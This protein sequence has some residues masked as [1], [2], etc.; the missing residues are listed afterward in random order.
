MFDARSKALEFLDR[1]FTPLFVSL[2][3]KRPRHQ[4]W[5]NIVQTR[6]N[7][8]RQFTRPAN[9]G[10]RTGD[11]HE[12]GSCLVAVDIDREDHELLA[13]HWGNRTG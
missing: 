4:D 5:P 12:D 8:E 7:V 13:C 2:G 9:I 11:Q 3:T 6:E 10:I 1:G